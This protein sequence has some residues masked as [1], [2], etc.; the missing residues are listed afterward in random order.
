MSHMIETMTYVGAT[1]W[2]ELGVKLDAPPT[3]RE[4]IVAAGLDWEVGLKDLRTVDGEPV[5]HRATYRKSD[6]A[7]LGVVGP[8][9]HPI[10]NAQA[11]DWFDPFVTSKEASIETAGSL[12]GGKRIWVLARINRDPSTIVPGDEIQKY[13][14]LANAHD[15]TLAGRVGFTPVRVVC[16][17]TLS[18]AMG[19]GES[20]LVRVFHTKNAVD[21][22]AKV[23]DIMNLANQ[24]FEATAEQYRYLA[25]RS[26][27]AGDLEKYV[28]LVFPP[29]V[30]PVVARSEG[31]LAVL[32]DEVARKS[33]TLEAIRGLFEEGVGNSLPGVRGTYW[34]AYNAVTE[35]TTHHRGRD[36]ESRL[37]A[38]F[39]DGALINRRA[40]SSAL[41]LAA[42]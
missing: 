30:K 2:H 15:G 36:A 3:T 6:G 28:S 31:A 22:L 27:H 37:N 20:R 9:Y 34:A 19:D 8:S 40:L 12:E 4:A 16:H 10:Q 26:L 32:R 35:Y 13:I 5:S 1:P 18:M 29:R 41:S 24:Q 25:S 38:S 33:P 11:F 39:S 42:A 17:N 14:L 23:R 21:V 7:I